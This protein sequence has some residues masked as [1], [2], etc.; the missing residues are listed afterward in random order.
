[1]NLMP[2]KQSM[3]TKYWWEA[4]GC[5]K[6]I[7]HLAIST[8]V[9]SSICALESYCKLLTHTEI[10]I[11]I[12]LFKLESQK[13]LDMIPLTSWSECCLLQRQICLQ[14]TSSS[15]PWDDHAL[16]FVW[17]THIFSS[18]Y[19]HPKAL[20]RYHTEMQ[21][22]SCLPIV[23]N[24]FYFTGDYI[25]FCIKKKQKWCWHIIEC[26]LI[27][28]IKIPKKMTTAQCISLLKITSI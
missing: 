20:Y 28:K 5:N 1:M 4:A 6:Y 3:M 2:Q 11:C 8:S 9:W 16:L 17:K 18:F 24:H 23:C 21:G 19:F 13:Q 7:G 22:Y 10:Y 27:A 12:I 14:Q 25:G 15:T 26:G